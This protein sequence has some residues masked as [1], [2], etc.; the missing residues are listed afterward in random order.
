MSTLPLLLYPLLILPMV[1]IWYAQARVQQVFREEDRV[2][3]AIGIT[4]LEA[5]RGLLNR[6]GLTRV[7]IQV[8]S[9]LLSDQYS[10]TTKT[11]YLSPRTVRH[12]SILAVGV[13]AHEVAHALQDA[14][15]YPLMSV[16]NVLARWL[17]VLGTISP[18]A[19]IGGFLFGS[20]PLMLVAVGILALQV[21]FALVTLPLEWNASRR[22]RRLLLEHEMI[23]SSEER[24]VRRVLRAAAFTYLASVGVR[25]AFF[26]FWFIVLASI[27]RAGGG[28]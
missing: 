4:G 18:F 6:N 7:M 5:A 3:N 10:P 28:S 14:Q 12:G 26:L 11:L 9:G 8:R 23:V 19:F 27:A 13:A 25:L 20:L 21:I 22:A 1:L 16:H 2:E 17:M 24:G 15:G